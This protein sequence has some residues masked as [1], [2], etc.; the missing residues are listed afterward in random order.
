MWEN[1]LCRYGIPR[2][3]AT[4]NGTHFNNEEF[5][6]YCEVNEIELRFTSVAH[7]QANGQAKVENRIILD[8]PKKRIEKSKNNLVDEILPIL[9]DYQT[10]CRITTGATP[11]MLAYG[12]KAVVLVEISHSTPKIQAYNAE[13]KEE[14][15][16]LALDLVDEVRDEAHDKIVDY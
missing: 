11:F 7:P 10:T 4:D 5:W 14:G 12:A 16:R 9:W 2:I 13:E 3:L 1:I 15:K 8:G 6:K